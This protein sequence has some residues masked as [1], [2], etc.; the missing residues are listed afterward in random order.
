MKKI[1]K[2]SDMLDYCIWYL[3]EV[4]DKARAVEMASYALEHKLVAKSTPINSESLAF[5]LRRD[6]FHKE[7]GKAGTLLY[8]LKEID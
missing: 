6:I 1:I 3:Q 2:K 4:K 5:Y 7:Q 8:S